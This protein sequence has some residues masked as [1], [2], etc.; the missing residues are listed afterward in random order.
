MMCTQSLAST[1]S[2]FACISATHLVGQWIALAIAAVVVAAALPPL[3]LFN[4][5]HV[6]KV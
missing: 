5:A 2:T 1:L 4:G 6:L 3:S